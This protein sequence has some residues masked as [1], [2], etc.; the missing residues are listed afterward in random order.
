MNVSKWLGTSYQLKQQRVVNRIKITGGWVRLGFL[1]QK[2]G[3]PSTLQVWT[4]KNHRGFYIVTSVHSKPLSVQ[5]SSVQS[6]SHVRLFVTPRIAAC[7][8][9]LSITNSQSSLRLTSIDS[10]MPSSHLILCCP[11]LLLPPIPPS[12]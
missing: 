4:Q 11:L 12:I 8:A 1:S 9:S 5:F 2:E 3:G 6:L 10:V 7:Q